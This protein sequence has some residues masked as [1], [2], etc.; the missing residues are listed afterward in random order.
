MKIKPL[1]TPSLRNEIFRGWSPD[2]GLPAEAI[3]RLLSLVQASPEQIGQVM[4]ESPRRVHQV[5]TRMMRDRPIEESIAGAFSG[6]GLSYESIWGIVPPLDFV[7]QK[8]PDAFAGIPV[9]TGP[10]EKNQHLLLIADCETS[11]PD[12]DHHRLVEI[13]IVKVVLG[14]HSDGRMC[15]LGAIDGYTG[16][17]DPGPHPVNPVSMRIHGIPKETLLGKTLDMSHITRVVEG[18]EAV[19][20]HNVS[21]DRRFCTK[22][23]PALLGLPWVCSYIGVPWKALGFKDAKLKTIAK[24]MGVRIPTH[25]ASGDVGALYEVLNHPLADGLSGIEHMLQRHCR[26]GDD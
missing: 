11:G 3:L 8:I 24:E 26:H 18:A 13:A 17:Q 5:I 20:A 14:P 23:V 2:R 21:F 10:I 16:L 22:S 25:R 7:R 19:I 1:L 4:E 9:Y 12:A 6:L 15:L